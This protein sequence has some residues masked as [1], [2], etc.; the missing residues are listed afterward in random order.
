M[1]KQKIVNFNMLY[2]MNV[3]SYKLL[4]RK[5]LL[6]ELYK[7]LIYKFN[8]TGQFVPRVFAKFWKQIL[9]FLAMCIGSCMSVTQKERLCLNF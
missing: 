2:S 5:Q 7:P 9:G 1:P 3:I 8:L 6:L 4:Y